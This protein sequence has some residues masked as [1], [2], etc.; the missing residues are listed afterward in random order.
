MCYMVKCADAYSALLGTNDNVRV[1]AYYVVNW[2][3]VKSGCLQLL[4]LLHSFHI[5]DCD[6]GHYLNKSL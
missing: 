3:Y 5:Y 2:T 4:L 1:F 6:S